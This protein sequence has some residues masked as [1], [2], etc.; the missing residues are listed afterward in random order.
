MQ[1]RKTGIAALGLL[2]A[3]TVSASAEI[4]VSANDGKQMKDGDIVTGP[5]PD[6]ISVL[7]ISGDQVKVIGSVSCWACTRNLVR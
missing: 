7:N 1:G 6:S 5:Q 4:A 2:L 3:M